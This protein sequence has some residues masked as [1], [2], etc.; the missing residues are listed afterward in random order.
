MKKNVLDET[1]AEI[2]GR[3]IDPRA[4]SEAA[5][6]VRTRVL[7]PAARDAGIRQIRGCSDFQA[8]MP[9]YT[10]GRLSEARRLLLEDHTLS[11]VHCRHALEAERSGKVRTLPRPVIE[12]KRVAPQWKW[13]AAAAVALFAGLGTWQLYR[14]LAPDPGVRAVVK[15]VSGT[16]FAVGENAAAPMF[17]GR[18]IADHQPVRTFEKSD[19]VL[20]LTDGSEVELASRSELWIGRASRETTIHLTRGSIIVHAAKQRTGALHVAT[21]NCLVSVKGT[22][23]AVTEGT[24]GSR[25]SV[26]EGAVQVREGSQVQ[27]LHPGQQTTTS[28]AV[29]KTT[30]EDDIA[31]SR[32]AG[33]YLAV[34][35]EFT[36]MAKQLAQAP[37][38]GLRYSSKLAALAPPNTIIYGAMPNVGPLLSEANQIF[39]QH[40]AES[41]V[42][43]QWWNQHH[44]AEG[45]SL[46]Q[47]VQRVRTFSDYLGNEIALAISLDEN[48][49]QA[50]PML[51]AEVTRPG[52][53]NYLVSEGQQFN[54][55]AGKPVF[56]VIQSFPSAPPADSAATQTNS[57]IALVSG[58]YLFI[59]PSL[60]ALYRASQQVKDAESSGDYSLY[61]R[62]EEAYANGVAWLLAADMEQIRATTVSMQQAPG[63][64]AGRTL[65]TGIEN[66]GLVVLERKEMNG[67]TQ[68]VATL[69]FQGGRAGMAGWLAAPSPIGS[70]DFISP[71]ASLVTAAAIKEHGQIIW[72]LI[73]SAK[74]S[75][76]EISPNIDAYAG[77]GNWSDVVALAN[78]LGGDFTFAIDGPLLPVPS[79]KVA[80]EVLNPTNCQWAIEHIVTSVSQQAGTKVKL[81]LASANI[82]GR[83]FYTITADN[84]PLQINYVF[85]DNYLL[86]AATQDLLQQSIQNQQTG[87]TL[88]RSDAFRS[89][90]PKDGSIDFSGILY[91]NAGPALSTL[92]QGLNATNALSPTQKA[93]IN[94]IAA[95]S[96]PTLVYAYGQPESIQISSTGG[97]FG[98]N[99][100]TLSLPAIVGASMNEQLRMGLHR[101]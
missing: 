1:I 67:V 22:I 19:A 65:T 93:S 3:T 20:R 91:Y 59:S 15:S 55:A 78:S 69:S 44:P 75:H 42:L 101:E 39:D 62:I 88:A 4:I 56:Q 90:F 61:S 97:F 76:P 79:W 83:T 85:V 49:K 30:V 81:H 25:V 14:T 95:N 43:Q 41:Q 35:G 47:L 66:L 48:T 18:E 87:Y 26:V 84:F 33:Q 16:L 9:A 57:V 68:N 52:L 50:T 17:A 34:L 51:M 72:D 64:A 40:L 94:A 74:T 70:L 13:A 21:R 46:D 71:N 60:S 53:Y 27:M 7:T 92:A 12:E 82:G 96:K 38:P 54:A 6:R 11:C 5:A 73:H 10:M 86:A 8:L 37:Q 99:L 28:L 77:S 63:S 89:Q 100:D 31:W 45:P 23:F 24:K 36:S 2:H 58:N 29:A 32:N 80:V 98:L